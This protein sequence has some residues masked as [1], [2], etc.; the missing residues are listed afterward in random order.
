VD[1]MGGLYSPHGRDEKCTQN[2]GLK[3]LKGR[4]HLEEIGGG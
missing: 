2:F 1:E 3:T 4:H